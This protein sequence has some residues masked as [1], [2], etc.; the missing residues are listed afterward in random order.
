MSTAKKEMSKPRLAASVREGVGKSPMTAEAKFRKGELLHNCNTN[1]DGLVTRVYDF[2]A[3]ITY[4]VAVPVLRDT[5]AGSHYVSD[6][7]ES[8]LELSRNTHL[9]SSDKPPRDWPS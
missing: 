6:W 2:E 5:W 4:E 1:E 9:K 8:V 7:D 3:A